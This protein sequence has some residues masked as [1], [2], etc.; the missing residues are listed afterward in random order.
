M[1]NF[2]FLVDCGE[3]LQMLHRLCPRSQSEILGNL[4]LEIQK[5]ADAL[6]ELKQLYEL[7]VD[8]QMIIKFGEEV[9]Q[10]Q[11]SAEDLQLELGG[12]SHDLAYKKQK[13]QKLLSA[14]GAI[15][16]QLQLSS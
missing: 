8:F 16:G 9:L 7:C 10:Q 12:L 2:N 13:L 4:F 11:A 3:R 1:D 5:K 6:A 15:D 14:L